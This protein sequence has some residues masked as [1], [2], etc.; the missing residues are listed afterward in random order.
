MFILPLLLALST[1]Q[2]ADAP[3]VI[4]RQ[5]T[6]AVEG[7]SVA[8]FR[9]RWDARLRRNAND[10]PA[11][12]VQ[13]TIARLTYD[14]PS[15]DKLYQQLLRDDPA[16]VDRYAAFAR[17]GFAQGLALRGYRGEGDKQY[18]LARRDA[19][20][21]GDRLLEGETLVTI[22][23]IRSRTQGLDVQEA[24]FDS[25]ARMFPDT[26]YALRALLLWRWAIVHA[27]RGRP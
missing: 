12:L 11:L 6:L 15:A 10:R 4:L 19:R 25:A 9:K 1:A 20:A 22:A 2:D 13:A 3:R 7:D 24:T 27:L 8:Q 5:A 17:L 26:S 21:I 14:Y 23:V 18:E 16:Q